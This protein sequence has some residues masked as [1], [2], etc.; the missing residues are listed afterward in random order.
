MQKALR[1]LEA[2]AATA[3]PMAIAE[4]ERRSGLA[5]PTTHRV[6]RDLINYGYIDR[7]PLHRGHVGG[8]KLVGLAVGI[9]RSGALR[10]RRLDVLGEVARNCGESCH[11]AL[12]HGSHVRIVDQA[13]TAA[14]L[15]VQYDVDV[16]LPTHGTASGKVLLA[17]LPD[18]QRDAL[19]AARPL[20]RTTERTVTDRRRLATM[21]SD[22]REAGFALEEG[23]H[24]AGVTSIAVPV[25]G[26]DGHL[27]GAI[28]VSAPEVR[29][30]SSGAEALVPALR[31]AARELASALG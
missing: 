7:D 2:L 4:I 5:R 8:A 20:G 15:C 27:I 21:L 10:G 17:H 29:L 9:L 31:Q 26:S 12:L 3:S 22:I 16:L 18:G 30:N 25:S 28:G 23:E 24:I 14:P 11:F 13:F 1:I 6:T 19:L